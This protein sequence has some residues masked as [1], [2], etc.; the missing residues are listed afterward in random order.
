VVLASLPM[1]YI[2]PI[3]IH[4]LDEPYQILNAFDYKNAPLA[5]LANYFGYVFG[6]SFGWE[7]INF[8]Y[9]AYG[10]HKLAILIGCGYMWYK[11][12]QYWPCLI[13]T[14]ALLLISSLYGCWQNMY[15]WD[16]WTLPPV[17]CSIV[18]L[19]EYLDSGRTWLIVLLGLISA[20]AGLCRIPN[21]AIVVFICA[22]LLCWKGPEYTMWRKIK[23]ISIYLATTIIATLTLV[24]LL[25]GSHY[26]DYLHNNSISD[27][28]LL[29]VLIPYG[30]SIL[31]LCFPVVLLAFCYWILI[32]ANSGSRFV[33]VCAC[34]ITLIVLCSY[35]VFR[36]QTHFNGQL[37]LIGFVVGVILIIVHYKR[38]VAPILIAVILLGCIPFVGSNLGVIKFVTLPIIPVLYVLIRHDL[39]RTMII[40]SAIY[41]VS[42]IVCS[43]NGIRYSTLQEEGTLRAN[44]EV[45]TGLAKGL[46]TDEA[47]GRVMDAIASDACQYHTYTNIVLRNDT[48]YVYEYVL[49]SRNSYLRHQFDGGNDNDAKYVAWVEREINN[50]GDKVAIW[51]FGDCE[52]PS[53]MTDVLNRLCTKEKIAGAY[54]I[55]LKKIECH[56]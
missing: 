10:L 46:K 53:L 11:T 47:K 27:H 32:K 15:G 41:Y 8:R 54:T 48:K 31:E 34:V 43:Y 18:V 7:W 6:S 42:L 36:A 35:C 52:G 19:L 56:E 1:L 12:R 24:A 37:Y 45:T 40:F 55:Y 21:F 26:A 22:I 25:Y 5:P 2:A 38:S 3:G 51:R 29:R 39:R 50:G 14:V 28:N 23:L 49:Q 9:L 13:I 4:V 30:T 33:F 44:Y 17:V 16:S 20:L